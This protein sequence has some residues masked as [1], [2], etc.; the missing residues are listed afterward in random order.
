MRAALRLVSAIALAAACPAGPA[1]AACLASEITGIGTTSTSLSPYN[2]FASSTPKL[3]TVSVSATRPCTVE[4]AFYSMSMPAR[5]SGPE[6][7]A[8]DVQSAAGATSLLYNGGAPTNSAVIDI[9]AGNVGSASVQISVPAGQVVSDGLYS[10]IALSA[11]V[12][13]RSGSAF[14]LLRSA[15]MPVT[16]SVAKACQFTTPSSPTLNFSAGI[17]NGRPNPGYV[18]SLALSGV[19]CTAP[20]LVRLSGGALQLVQPVAAPPGLDNRIHYR[21]SATF[22]AASAV[23]DTSVASEVSSTARNTG[24]GATIN[25]SI[26][27]DVTLLAGR[28]LLAGAYA[29]TL[30][31]SVDPSP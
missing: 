29:A 26:G 28:P 10:D 8:Y 30:T 7:L 9:G 14:T 24:T 4:L 12:F 11:H 20:T 3:V 31:V 1:E 5:M 15:A 19:N 2:P 16:A 6:L 21:A 27:I 25:G 13:D 18:Q 23:L 17:T 22:N